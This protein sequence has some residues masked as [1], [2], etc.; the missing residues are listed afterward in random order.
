MD[1]VV[2][3][4]LAE[5]D[6][7]QSP[8]EGGAGSTGNDIFVIGA[9]NRCPPVAAVCNTGLKHSII[10]QLDCHTSGL[11]HCQ[12][13]AGMSCSAETLACSPGAHLATHMLLT[14]MCDMF[15]AVD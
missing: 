10:W 5:L 11:S 2:A 6:G 9:T 4:L 7:A 15:H 13:A 3:Q 14:S 1:R 8:S 12:C